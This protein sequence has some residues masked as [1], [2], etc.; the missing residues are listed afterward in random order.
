M[1]TKYQILKS[2]IEVKEKD[3]V[4]GKFY[5]LDEPWSDGNNPKIIGTCQSLEEARRAVEGADISTPRHM[6]G[7]VPYYLVEEVYIEEVK[8]NHEFDEWEHV[9]YWDS[10]VAK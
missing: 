2:E 4:E 9:E 1:E 10:F 5:S 3:W 8:Y 6:G 7:V